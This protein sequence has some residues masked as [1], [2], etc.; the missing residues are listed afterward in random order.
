[1]R[2]NLVWTPGAQTQQTFALCTVVNIRSKVSCVRVGPEDT[3]TLMLTTI[4][5]L[6]YG[7]SVLCR[8]IGYAGICR[9]WSRSSRL[10]PWGRPLLMPQQGSRLCSRTLTSVCVWK[11]LFMCVLKSLFFSGKL[12]SDFTTADLVLTRAL[13]S[14]ARR[15]QI[16]WKGSV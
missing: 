7:C 3:V 15:M 16:R 9:P 12:S 13:P 2:M 10:L 5:Q 1:M 4:T 8:S 11:F 14:T 6:D